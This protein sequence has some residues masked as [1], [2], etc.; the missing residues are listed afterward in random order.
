[1]RAG[2]DTWIIFSEELRGHLRSRWYVFFTV[3]VVILLVIAM[4]VVPLF[5]NGGGP[6]A[7]GA[8]LR[9]IGFVDESGLLPSLGG[10]AG[11]VRFDSRAA[12]LQAVAA[13]R[14]D[15]LYVI[16]ANYL[17][18]GRIEQYAKFEGRF[19][20]SPAGEDAF[21]TS[22][23]QALIAGQVDDAVA[24]RVL[25]PAQLESFRVTS[26]ATVEGLTPAAQ[27]AGS[28]VVPMLF[29]ALLGMGL[30][31]SFG[32]MV[33]SV[34]EEKESRLVEVIVTST[35]PFSIVAGRLL[36][37]LVMGLAQAAVWI[38]AA[39]LTMPRIFNSMGGGTRFTV[40]AGLWGMIVAAFVTGYLLT[41]A[42]SILIG[43]V[44]PSSREAGRL[45]G[46]IAALGFVPFWFFALLI[47]HPN[48]LGSRIMSYFPLV[49]P[50]GL[51]L[52]SGVGGQMAAW[53]IVAGF[54]GVAATAGVVLWI[55]GRV[56]RAAILMRGQHLSG[57]NLWA[58][59]R[60]PD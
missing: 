21:R 7:V 12:G 18:S 25:D 2:T 56:F 13:D 30:A 38:I 54:A 37:L 23:V 22:L 42:L 27:A 10:S 20:S 19:P 14:V 39:A 52:R 24:A 26:D 40:S 50:T 32:Y 59:L 46:W 33:T 31:V 58:A 29:A 48:G 55:A 57:H 16:G 35:S 9:R 11:P 8:D 17:Q 3:L 4:F 5:E 44:A 28:L 47:T 36:A 43:A 34:S 51:L 41:T 15:S 53:Q 6:A 60:D 45:G 49:A 1:M